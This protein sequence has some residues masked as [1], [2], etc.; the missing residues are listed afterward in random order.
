MVDTDSLYPSRIRQTRDKRKRMVKW[1]STKEKLEMIRRRSS[2]NKEQ[3]Q[4]MWLNY[5]EFCDLRSAASKSATESMDRGFSKLLTRLPVNEN[6]A[7]L[8]LDLWAKVENDSNLRGLER[9][10]SSDHRHKRDEAKRQTT[11]AVLEAQQSA[12]ENDGLENFAEY[13]AAISCRHSADSR[14]FAAMMGIADEK[15]IR[16]RPTRESR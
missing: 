6:L 12:K 7:Q 9:Y 13:L 14:S 1:P 15:A 16:R 4:S 5:E 2:V 3:L 11:L 10:V 8:R